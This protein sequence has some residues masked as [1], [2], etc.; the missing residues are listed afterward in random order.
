MTEIQVSYGRSSR[1]LQSLPRLMNLSVLL[2]LSDWEY[3]VEYNDSRVIPCLTWALLVAARFSK[4]LRHKV[5]C[6]CC[7]FV[8]LLFLQCTQT[9]RSEFKTESRK[10]AS[11]WELSLHMNFKSEALRVESREFQR[12]LAGFQGVPTK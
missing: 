9:M 11:E 7:F 12:S 1:S 6:F 5:I 8:C 2:Y 10:Q 4:K 3:G